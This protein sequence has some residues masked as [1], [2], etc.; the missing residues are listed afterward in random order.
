MKSLESQIDEDT[1]AIVINNP[2]NP[3]GSVFSKKH[4]QEILE[5]ASRHCLP[6][7]ADEIYEHLVFPGEEFHPIASLSKDVPILSCSGLTKRLAKSE[8]LP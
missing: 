2:S 6:I 7:I 8:S 1:V 5:I 4:L 3:C